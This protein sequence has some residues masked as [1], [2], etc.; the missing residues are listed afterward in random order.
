MGVLGGAAG[1]AL[2]N[3]L[4]PDSPLAKA[5][6]GALGGFLIPFEKGGKVPM[7]QKKTTKKTTNKKKKGK[8]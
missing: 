7:K 2:A 3:W 8:K 6:G 1:T 5:A 4:F